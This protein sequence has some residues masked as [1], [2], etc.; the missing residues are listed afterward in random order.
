MKGE[1]L[2]KKVILI[3]EDLPKEQTRAKEAVMATGYRPVLANNLKDANRLWDS[4]AGKIGGILTDL[5]FPQHG[6]MGDAVP[7]GITIVLRAVAEDISVVVC[8]DA[9]HGADYI[10]LAIKSLEKMTGKVIPVELSK[11]Y[12]VAIQ[13]LEEMMKEEEKR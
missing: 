10:K 9:G 4:L 1:C 3:V 13:R 8:T 5:H 7:S 6:P 11:N 2:M 12:S